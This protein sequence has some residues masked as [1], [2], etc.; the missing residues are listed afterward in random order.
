M[1]NKKLIT[2]A[3]S[4]ALLSGIGATSVQAF[5]ISANVALVSDYR[6]RGISQTGEDAAVQGGFDWSKD[7]FISL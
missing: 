1:L 5:D 4:T 7:I 2:V 6:F 3:V